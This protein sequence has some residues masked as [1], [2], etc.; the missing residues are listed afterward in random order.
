MVI[1][2]HAVR[3]AAEEGCTRSQHAARWRAL[4]ASP[5]GEEQA[6]AFAHAG[7]PAHATAL[8]LRARAR[9]QGAWRRLPEA[10]RERLRGL[11]Q[12]R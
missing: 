10:Q 7:A 8:A 2:D 3:A 1:A 11:F 5:G 6:L 4:Q 12:R 9:G